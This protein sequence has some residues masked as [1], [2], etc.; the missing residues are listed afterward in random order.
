MFGPRAHQKTPP[1][2]LSS[3]TTDLASQQQAGASR[4]STRPTCPGAADLQA[5]TRLGW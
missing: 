1:H 3:Q 4:M 5:V 2:S